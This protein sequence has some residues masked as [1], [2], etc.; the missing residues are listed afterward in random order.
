MGSYCLTCWLNLKGFSL[1]SKECSTVLQQVR[2]LF[3]FFFLAFFLNVCV[4]I[5]LSVMKYHL[6]PKV[7]CKYDRKSLRETLEFRSLIIRILVYPNLS[8]VVQ[9]TTSSIQIILR[10]FTCLN[11]KCVFQQFWI[12]KLLYLVLTVLHSL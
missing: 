1:Y 11:Q 10:T 12:I 8:C 3:I 9:I 7:Y 2:F 4:L 6:R 5:N